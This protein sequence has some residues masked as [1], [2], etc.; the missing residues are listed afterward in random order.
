[1]AQ[2][3]RFYQNWNNYTTSYCKIYTEA[4]A[5]KLNLGN[6]DAT[7]RQ[8]LERMLYQISLPQVFRRPLTCAMMMYDPAEFGELSVFFEKALM[9]IHGMRTKRQISAINGPLTSLA[10]SILGGMSSDNCKKRICSMVVEHA[11]LEEV[12]KNMFN[13]NDVYHKGWR[14][15]ALYYFF[16]GLIYI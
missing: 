7:G 13:G 2:L 3:L 10:N 1:M 5:H 6:M 4:A 14:G 12:V 15:N 9:R 16:T 8:N 11:S